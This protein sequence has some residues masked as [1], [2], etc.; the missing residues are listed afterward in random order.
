M[1]DFHVMLVVSPDLTFLAAGIHFSRSARSCLFQQPRLQH[2][3]F[4]SSFKR[5]QISVD[6]LCLMDV[7]MVVLGLN[8]TALL[9]FLGAIRILLIKQIKIASP[10]SIE[11]LAFL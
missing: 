8:W 9:L 1:F 5:A 3:P 11:G 6:V 4:T 7:M 2:H 10:C